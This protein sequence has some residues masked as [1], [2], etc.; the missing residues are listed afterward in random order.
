M[1]ACGPS[2]WSTQRICPN[3]AAGKAKTS[4]RRPSS[5]S[6]A[7]ITLLL[8][9]IIADDIGHDAGYEVGDQT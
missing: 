2:F 1:M 9:P 5:A 3:S 6:T 7:K 8:E 4:R